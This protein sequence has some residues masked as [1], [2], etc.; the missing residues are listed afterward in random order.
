LFVMLFVLDVKRGR[1]EKC[2]LIK[3]KTIKGRG[4]K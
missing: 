2:I 4:I 1:E 3:K